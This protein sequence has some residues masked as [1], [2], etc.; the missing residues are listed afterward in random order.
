MYL[1]WILK[2]YFHPEKYFL[3]MIVESDSESTA[4]EKDLPEVIIES[5]ELMVEIDDIVVLF[6]DFEDIVKFADLHISPS[7]KFN[8]YIMTFTWS[9]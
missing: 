8:H 9:L 3:N 5:E 7:K 6:D 1:H 2:V 4:P